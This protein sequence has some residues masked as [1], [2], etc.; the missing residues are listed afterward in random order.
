MDFLAI[1]S[2]TKIIGK[3]WYIYKNLLVFK[4]LTNIKFQNVSLNDLKTEKH[5]ETWKM[6]LF[7]NFLFREIIYYISSAEFKHVLE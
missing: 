4:S 1:K 3:V 6:C 5:F 2:G 7:F